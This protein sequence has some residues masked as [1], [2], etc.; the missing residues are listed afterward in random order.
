M[1]ARHRLR[2]DIDALRELAGAKVFARGEAYHRGGQIEI[3]IN[4]PGRGTRWLKA[5]PIAL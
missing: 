3:L 1:K 4:K 5:P 2:F